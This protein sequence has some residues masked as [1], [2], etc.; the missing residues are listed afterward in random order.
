[1]ASLLVMKSAEYPHNKA[2]DFASTG[3]HIASI[4]TES[5]THMCNRMITLAYNIAQIICTYIIIDTSITDF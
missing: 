3:S 2:K 4:C 5:N 1:M